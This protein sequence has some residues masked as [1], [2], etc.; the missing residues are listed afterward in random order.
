MPQTIIQG[1]TV[2]PVNFVPNEVKIINKFYLEK[3]CQP[4]K[5]QKIIDNIAKDFKLNKGQERAYRIVANHSCNENAEQLKMNL[6]GMAGTGKTR[7]LKA[8]IDLFNHKKEA[9]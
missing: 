2:Q 6:A 4:L 3:R 7:V 1:K 9:H 5:W 8:L